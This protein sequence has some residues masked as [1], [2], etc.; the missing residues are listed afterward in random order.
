MKIKKREDRNAKGQIENK[1]KA[2]DGRARLFCIK[3]MLSLSLHRRNENNS[4]SMLESSQ[5]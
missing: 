3:T 1:T 4:K 2:Y 5:M